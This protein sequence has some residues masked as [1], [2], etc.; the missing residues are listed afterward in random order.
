MS[1]LH[2]LDAIRHQAAS[3]LSWDAVKTNLGASA[4][5]VTPAAL[6]AFLSRSELTV[7][8]WARARF[9]QWEVGHFHSLITEARKLER[10][11]GATTSPVSG[12]TGMR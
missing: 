9:K 4:W 3:T 6:A 8:K 5:L 11:V 10:D 12:D 1:P 2:Y 7:A